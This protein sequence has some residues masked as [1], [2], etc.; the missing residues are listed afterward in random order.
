MLVSNASYMPGGLSSSTGM[1][2]IGSERSN[3]IILLEK[4]VIFARI[5][6]LEKIAVLATARGW[7]AN[8]VIKVGP[9]LDYS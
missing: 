7:R 8:M 4:I 9:E 2:K 1:N 6:F 3:S 5:L